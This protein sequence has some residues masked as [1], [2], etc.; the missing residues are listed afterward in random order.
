MCANPWIAQ[1]EKLC[2][3]SSCSSGRIGASLS[4][5]TTTH[6]SP[7]L[8]TQESLDDIPEDENMNDSTLTLSS[9]FKQQALKNSKGKGFWDTFSESSSIGGARI[10]PPPMP[11]LPRGSSSGVSEDVSMDSPSLVATAGFAIDLSNSNSNSQP[12]NTPQPS[13]SGTQ[14]PSA[15][16]I[17]RRINSKRRRDDDFDP[18][19]FKRRAVSPGMSVHNSPIMQSPLQRDVQPWG[20]RPGSNSGDKNGNGSGA[21]SEAGSVAGNGTPSSGPNGSQGG[22]VNG[23]KGRV[24]YQGMVDTNE[25]MMRM[26]IE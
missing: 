21:A 11:F 7:S 26:S 25:H 6:S 22:R 2:S 10:T 9:S 24:G 3:Y 16:E 4:G 18:V 5:A 15:A 1:D 8:P 14:P 13:Q 20:S 12:S 17:T 19:S 23:N